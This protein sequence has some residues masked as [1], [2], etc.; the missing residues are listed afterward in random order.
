MTGFYWN[1]ATLSTFFI[2]L[3]KLKKKIFEEEN[4]TKVEKILKKPFKMDEK[5]FSRNA[6]SSCHK[7]LK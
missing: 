4:G 6:F 7:I 1:T 3:F 5:S 2:Q